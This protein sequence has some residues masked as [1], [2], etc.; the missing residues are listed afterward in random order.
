MLQT[1]VG[2]HVNAHCTNSPSPGQLSMAW[3]CMAGE[4]SG[5]YQSACDPTGDG[6]LSWVLS[7][8]D[9]YP[10]GVTLVDVAYASRVRLWP[11]V[12]NA[13]QSATAELRDRMAVIHRARR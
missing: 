13:D 3:A 10:A 12:S 5:R 4:T 6:T 11:S 2:A 7:H 8:L 9:P 1:H